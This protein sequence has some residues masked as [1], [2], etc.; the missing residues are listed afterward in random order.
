MVNFR[1]DG[2]E[3]RCKNCMWK[4]VEGGTCQDANELGDTLFYDQT[5]PAFIN[6]RPYDTT[7]YDAKGGL[8][9]TARV[10]HIGYGLEE[11]Q[12]RAIVLNDSRGQPLACGILEKHGHPMTHPKLWANLKNL[13]GHPE[14]HG[15]V[16]LDFYTDHAFHVGFDFTGAPPNCLM[17]LISIHVGTSCTE[18]TGGVFWNT[19]KLPWNPW[20]PVNGAYYASDANGT[21]IDSHGFYFYDGFEYGD[22]LDHVVIVHDAVGVRI[23]CGEL[24]ESSQ[25]VWTETQAAVRVAME[26]GSLVG[27]SPMSGA[28]FATG[29][30]T[31]NLVENYI[32]ENREPAV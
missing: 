14:M 32:N 18:H 11:T 9:E 10:V 27:A 13:P 24:R 4:I 28:Q 21:S 22:H 29:V 23:A 3:E 26:S 1:V 17:C 16:R 8:S 2:L 20:G 5:D 12:N 6:S 15:K 25:Y 7:H 30:E 31:V 19:E